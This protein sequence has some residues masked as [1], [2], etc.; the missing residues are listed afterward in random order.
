MKSI[1]KGPARPGIPEEFL[2]PMPMNETDLFI[3]VLPHE[4]FRYSRVDIAIEHKNFQITRINLWTLAYV[5]QESGK[6]TEH[7]KYTHSS[8]IVMVRKF[9]CRVLFFSI[10]LGFALA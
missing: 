3:K 1:G 6:S 9:S 2:S 4:S 5:I 8:E 10:S 7:Q